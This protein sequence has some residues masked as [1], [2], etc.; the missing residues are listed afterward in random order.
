MGLGGALAQVGAKV[1]PGSEY[2]RMDGSVVGK[3]LTTDSSGWNGMYGMHRADILR[4][5]AEALPPGS[6]HTAHR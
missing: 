1:G 6:I 2:H 3:I 4:V 5:L